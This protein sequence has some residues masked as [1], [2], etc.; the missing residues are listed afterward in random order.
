L[1]HYYKKQKKN[2][3][4]SLMNI[5]QILKRKAEIRSQL[6][7][8]KEVDLKALETELRELNTK[9]QEL[10]EAESVAAQAELR[11][12]LL[13]EATVI[14]AESGKGTEE[15]RSI[16]TFTG[17]E[18]RSAEQKELEIR[19]KRGQALKEKRSVT[20]ATSN[21]LLPTPQGNTI[22]PTFNE[23]SSLIDRVAQKNLTGG[24]SFSQPYVAGYGTGDYTAEGADYV[25][26]DVQFGYAEIN[27]TKITS[28][29][30]DTEEILKLPAADYEGEV[31]KGISVA[32]R[33]KMSREILVGD[34][35]TG[36]FIGIFSAQATAIDPATDI[37]ISAIDNKTLD[38][39]VY[40]YGGDEDVE[41][42]AVL[43]LN[44]KDL[45]AFA[46][47]RSTTGEKIYDI[48]T[49]GNT[50]T[51]NSVPFVINSACLSLSDAG[52]AAGAYSMA[53]GPMSNYLVTT[54]SDLEVLRSTDYK[55]KEGMIAHKGSVFAGGNVVHKNGFLRVK[56]A[57]VA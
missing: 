21:V 53:Y 55:F 45:K 30:E 2:G 20:V 34:G 50:G 54:F 24:E 17:E 8:G 49:K 6:E 12:K 42:T 41:D 19:E 18:Q 33:K 32:A 22:N 51:I 9:E 29:S 46:E 27:K 28:Y 47:V 52:T 48:V 56:K 38:E 39:I 25:D 37:E 31:M 11:K 15:H 14:N 36:H 1:K 40:S 23:V 57:P 4:N 16:E 10:R 43:I 3:G 35:G 5:E 44:K 7:G 13:A 26:G